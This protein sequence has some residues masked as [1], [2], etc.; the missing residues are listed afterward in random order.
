MDRRL[1]LAGLALLPAGQALAVTADELPLAP[2]PA[3]ADPNAV[4]GL[5]W[6]GTGPSAIEVFDYNC[7]YC[8]KAFHSLDALVTKKKL[9]LGLMDSPML[10]P[11]SVQAAKL[12]QAV[13]IV[14]GPD[15]AFAFHRRLYATKGRIDG[16]VAVAAAQAMGLDVHKLADVANS[17]EVRDRIIAQMH[18]LDRIGVATTPSFIIKGR[19]LS[20]WPGVDGFALALKA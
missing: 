8:R 15:K 10:S 6:Y 16:D 19:L 14:Y 4:P 13:L 2:L 9:R 11:G 20:G 7:P 1:F 12:R 3:G 18:F 5:S 17:Q